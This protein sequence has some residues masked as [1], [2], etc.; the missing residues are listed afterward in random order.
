[1]SGSCGLKK[2]TMTTG[3]LLG[4]LSSTDMFTEVLRRKA[5]SPLRLLF[6][7]L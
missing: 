1:M 2:A 7:F 4:T 5:S 3:L 6:Q